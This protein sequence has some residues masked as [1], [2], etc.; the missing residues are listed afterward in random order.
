MAQREFPQQRLDPRFPTLELLCSFIYFH[1]IFYQIATVKGYVR[2][3][4][5][6]SKT[7]GGQ[8]LFR[9][10]WAID[11]NRTYKAAAKNFPQKS[12]RA[13]RPLTVQI[14]KKIKTH[15]DPKS[16]NDRAIWALLSLGVFTLARIGELVPGN[17]S[18]I[19]ITKGSVVIRGDHGI[20]TLFGTKTD[21]ENRG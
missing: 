21:H 1:C 4:G 2:R 12:R 6:V 10:E 17:S 11:I 7:K 14:L 15:L 5:T 18:K 8:A 9:K 20:L 3:A 19:K 16:H 13:R